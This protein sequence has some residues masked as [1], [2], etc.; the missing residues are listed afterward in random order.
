MPETVQ[1]LKNIVMKGIEVI[2]S[3][4][5]DLA[6]GARQRVDVYNLENKRE[7]LLTSIGSQ[8]FSLSEKGTMFPDEIE[9]VLKE[10]RTIDAELS[11]IQSPGKQEE[12]T[13]EDS[14]ETEKTPEYKEPAAEKI[15][16]EEPLA[17][18]YTAE[19]DTDIPVIRVEEDP[20]EPKDTESCPLS[21]AIND[22]FEKTPQMDKMMDKVNNSLDELGDNLLKFSGEFDRQL[23]DFADQMMGTERK[24][25]EK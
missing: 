11:A 12:K 17:A 24:D 1:N 18:E 14:G 20:D 13:A 4:A 25:N 3:K 21:S 19:N 7:E 9:A 16:D 23:S 6:S 10:I 5:N 2:S 8:V 15:P 22:L